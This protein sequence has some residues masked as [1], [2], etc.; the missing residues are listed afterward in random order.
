MALG[1]GPIVGGALQAGA[2][3]YGMTRDKNADDDRQI[4]QQRRLTEMQKDA[5][6][7]AMENSAAQQMKMWN[8]TN[9]GAQKDH[10][11]AAG[12]NPGLMYGMSGGGG[13]TTG[14]ATQQGV[15]GGQAASAAATEQ[16]KLAMGMQLAQ[17]GL[18]IAQAEKTRAETENLKAGTGKTEVDTATGKLDL[19]TK[20]KTQGATIQTIEETAAKALADAVRSQQQQVITEETMNSQIEKIKT[21]AIGAMIENEARKSGIELNAARIKEIAVNIE[22]RWRGQEI[23]VENNKRMTEAMLWGAGIH[24]AGSLVNGIVNVAG[25]GVPNVV[26]HIK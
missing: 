14:S 18:M 11:I 17:Q 20:Q 4:E 21:D 3:I 2:A 13:V 10:M 7:E 16:N 12:L 25:K 1:I 8:D 22:Q 5:N 19:D 15:G 24:A 23:D 9:Y 26:K 6:K